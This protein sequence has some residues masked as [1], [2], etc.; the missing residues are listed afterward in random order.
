MFAIY[1]TKGHVPLPRN[2]KD[3]ISKVQQQQKESKA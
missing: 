2:I 3:N 1:S